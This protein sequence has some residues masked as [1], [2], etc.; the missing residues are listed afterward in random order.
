M[1]F[2]VKNTTLPGLLDLLAPHSCRGCGRIGAPLCNRCKNYIISERTAFQPD[3]PKALPPTFIL[4][5]RDG[6]VG[7]LIHDLKYHSVRDLARPLAQMLDQIL[8]SFD[9]HPVIIVP[10]P[11]IARHIRERG[12][13][14]TYLIAK[15]LAK[16]RGYQVEKLL[17]RAKNTVQVGSNR[18]SRLKQASAAYTIK[19]DATINPEATYLLFDDVWTTGA[20]MQAALQQIKTL[21]PCHLA[22]ALLAIS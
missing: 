11:T 14:H 18:H 20:T 12:L 3:L 7:K 21:Q 17:L 22:L 13:D 8:P 4:A 5:S 15:E 19:S 9:H 1:R 6:L 10:L 2:I 16:L